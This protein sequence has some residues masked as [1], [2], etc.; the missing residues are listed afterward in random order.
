[1]T[2]HGGRERKWPA[3]E[4]RIKA[5]TGEGEVANRENGREEDGWKGGEVVGHQ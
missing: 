5:V 2:N 4:E 1:M 3:V